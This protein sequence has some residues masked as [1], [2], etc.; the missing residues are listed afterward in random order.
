VP[1]LCFRTGL[2]VSRQQPQMNIVPCTELG[3]HIVDAGQHLPGALQ[4]MALELTEIN[5]AKTSPIRLV[6]W[7][8]VDTENIRCNR[9]VRTSS[10]ADSSRSNVNS[11]CFTDGRE[12]RCLTGAAASDQ[13][14]IDIKQPNL[15]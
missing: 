5:F 4:Q 11:E 9:P 2:D 8:L 15:H 1:K 6:V 12:R 10:K 3:K 7:D 13:R 14:S